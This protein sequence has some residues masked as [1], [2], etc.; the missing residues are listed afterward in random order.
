MN[1]V[2]AV[3]K[4][5]NF[6]ILAESMVGVVWQVNLET[7]EYDSILND[8]TVRPVKP[9]AESRSGVNGVNTRDGLL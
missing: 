3:E 7:S 8:M 9:V 4:G 5:S 1:G 2:T 6:I